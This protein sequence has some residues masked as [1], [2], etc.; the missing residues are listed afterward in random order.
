MFCFFFKQ[1]TAYEIKE[2][3]WSSDV[4]SSDLIASVFAA[5]S[6]VE[7]DSKAT[8]GSAPDDEEDDADEDEGETKADPKAEG[9]PVA[10]EAE[11]SGEE[12]GGVADDGFV[13]SVDAGDPARDD[14]EDDAGKSHESSADEDGGA[15]GGACSA[16]IFSSKSLT[17]ADGGGGR[18]PQRNHVSESHGVERDLMGGERDRAEFRN[19]CSDGGEDA[20]FE[21]ELHGGRNAEGDKLLDAA[22]IDV[23][24]SFQKLGV[25]LTVVPEEIAN[26]D[27]SHVN[28]R[29]GG[30]PTGTDGAHG[31]KSPFPVDQN[32]VEESVDDVGGDQS[33]GYGTNH[34]HG[35]QAA[36][37]GE[38]EEK[39]KQ[40]PGERVGVR[41]SLRHERGVD[42]NRAEQEGHEEN[43]R[44]ENRSERETEI[45]AVDERTVAVFAL[46]SAE[47]LG[48]DRVEA[49]E[50]TFAE[51]CEDD[52]DG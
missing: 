6:A 27:S 19:E 52:E 9:A 2:C 47:G 46:A 12:R 5:A 24:G 21:S 18:N 20:C 17:D 50:K 34:V 16:R 4:C 38:V 8:S 31:P 48:N 23:D 1:K 44:G 26:Q 29:N 36:A 37:N 45:N 15:S 14:Q 35:L 7:S 43:R 25:V 28:A 49:E 33:E 42:V 3:D 32:P 30:G 41:D 40:T 10:T 39:W 13:A 11:P 22:K 51:K